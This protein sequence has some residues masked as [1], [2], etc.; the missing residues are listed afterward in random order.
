MAL[1]SLFLLSAAPG[2]LLLLLLVLTG[3]GVLEAPN[4][5]AK[6][7]PYL[8]KT[9]SPKEKKDNDQDDDELGRPQLEWH[10]LLPP[11]LDLSLIIYQDPGQGNQGSRLP[12][13][14]AEEENGALQP[15]PREPRKYLVAHTGF[16]PVISSLR[17]RCPGPLDECAI[18]L[19]TED[20]NLT[21]QIQSLL[22]YR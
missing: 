21:K 5:L 15:W 6:S 9:G 14:Q 2:G 13:S 4:R 22:S 3:Y 8:G 20:S 7:S 18:W 1:G 19:G 12:S 17:G 10:V 11:F 16:E